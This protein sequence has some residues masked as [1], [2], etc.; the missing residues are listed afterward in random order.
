MK[1]VVLLL[2]LL[3]AMAM[4]AYAQL[5]PAGVPGA[6]GLVPDPEPVSVPA[7]P[8]P[9]PPELKKDA[10]PPVPRACAKSKNVERC[11]TRLEARKKAEAAC[12]GTPKKQFKQCVSNKLKAKPKKKSPAKKSPARKS[13][14]APERKT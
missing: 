10:P 12:K 8:P 14:A 4:P 6:P 3:T 13:P 2:S 1:S 7:P 9:A 5:G 11:V